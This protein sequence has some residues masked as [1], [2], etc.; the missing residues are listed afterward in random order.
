MEEQ[1]LTTAL[2][3]DN[4]SDA[5]KKFGIEGTEFVIMTGYMEGSGI[6]KRYLEEYNKILEEYRNK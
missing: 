2:I 3:R 6:Q 5:F 4:I 1:E